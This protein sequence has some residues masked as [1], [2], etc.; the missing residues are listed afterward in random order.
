MVFVAQNHDAGHGFA[1][2]L[3]FVD[4][5]F[6]ILPCVYAI[7]AAAASLVFGTRNA[8]SISVQSIRGNIRARPWNLVSFS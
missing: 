2:S 6:G 1:F 8:A 7:V 5:V 4:L 3:A